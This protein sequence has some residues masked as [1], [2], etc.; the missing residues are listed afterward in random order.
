MLEFIGGIAVGIVLGIILFCLYKVVIL[1][2][3]YKLEMTEWSD[4]CDMVYECGN[5]RKYT[6]TAE[7]KNGDESMILKG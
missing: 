5:N 1:K 3:F 7:Y 6:I 2:K 4:I